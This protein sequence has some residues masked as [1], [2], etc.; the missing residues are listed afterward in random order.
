MNVLIIGSGGREH[1]FC[2]KLAQSEVCD[3][4]FVA[5]GNAGTSRLATNLPIAVNDFKKLKK[6]V[7]FHNINLVVVGPE[8]SSC[9]W[10]P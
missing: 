2:W 9:K 7:L 10:H 4:L 8:D 3:H 6:E 1:T 5:P